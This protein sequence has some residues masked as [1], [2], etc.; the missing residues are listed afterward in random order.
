M[1]ARHVQLAD[2][3]QKARTWIRENLEVCAFSRP[4]SKKLLD[5]FST[6]S[7]PVTAIIP[8]WV[9][10][11]QLAKYSHGSV[12]PDRSPYR[13]GESPRDELVQAVLRYLETGTGRVVVCE[14]S[15]S[16]RK[17]LEIWTWSRPPR[18]FEYGRDNVYYLLEPSD[19]DEEMIDAALGDG[20]GSHFAIAIC[21]SCSQ[22]P[23]QV[24][25]DDAPLDELVQ[26]TRHILMPAFDG[27]GYMIWSPAV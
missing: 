20:L 18:Y 19:L 11:S 21:S 6:D 22:L 23:A 12:P 10:I 27:D 3:D 2:D 7:G 25:A 26:N 15:G 1:T 5:R 17:A 13:K 9:N 24:I 14:D 16:A 4:L 8:D